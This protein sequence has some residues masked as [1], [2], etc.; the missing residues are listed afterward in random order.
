MTAEAVEA[1]SKQKLTNLIKNYFINC[2]TD[3]NDI[4]CFKLIYVTTCM[5]WCSRR[6]MRAARKCLWMPREEGM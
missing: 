4:K 3:S 5:Y 1:D 2:T 6:V